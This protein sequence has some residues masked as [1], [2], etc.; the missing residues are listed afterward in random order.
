MTQ[1]FTHRFTEVHEL[2]GFDVDGAVQV[3]VHTIVN[4][5]PMANHQRGAVIILVGTMG[6][7]ATIDFALMQATDT[8]GTGAKAIAGKA[9]TQLTQAGGDGN[10][11]IIIEFRAEELD[12]D[13]GFAYLGAILTVTGAACEVAVIGFGGTSN[14]TPVPVTNWTEVVD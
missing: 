4:Y 14:Y 9:I 11:A 2:M 8:A 6:Q 7:G 12:V 13:G 3:G 10:D 5:R 1:A